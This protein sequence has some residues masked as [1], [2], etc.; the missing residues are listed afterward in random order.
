MIHSFTINTR[1][2]HRL[3]KALS[4]DFNLLS[5][6]MEK[7]ELILNL[8]D[9]KKGKTDVMLFGTNS[10]LLKQNQNVKISY[11]ANE[12]NCTE[13]YRYLGV[14]LDPTLNLGEHFSYVYKKASSRLQLLRRIR[15]QLT[16]IAAL[17][18][19]QSLII[20]IITYCSLTNYFSQSYR[21]RLLELLETRALNIIQYTDKRILTIEQQH[22]KKL[23]TTVHKIQF[24]L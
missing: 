5:N 11:R 16:N 21:F 13:T 6:W 4:S 18:V 24:Q 19:Y 7:N 9:L 14:N 23:L 8:N 12:I 22:Q 2:L 1:I 20:P 17:R 10:R 3:K 15:P